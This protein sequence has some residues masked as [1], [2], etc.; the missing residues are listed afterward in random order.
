MTTVLIVDDEPIVRDVVARYLKRDGF[1]TL[2]A[3]DGDAARELIER[4]PPAPRR[5]R[6]DAARHRWP[7]PL[8]VDPVA[9]R[10]ARDHA[11]RP[12][13]GGRPDRRPR[14]RRRRLRHQ[15]LLAARAGDAR[16]HGAAPQQPDGGLERASRR[17]TGSSS[18]RPRARCTLHGQ[19]LRL[20]AKEF[21]L[22]FFLAS[23]PRNVF[24]RDQLMSRVWGYEAALD[25]GTVTVH[26]RRLRAKIELD[27]AQPAPAR[28]D[29]GRRLQVPAVIALALAVAVGTLAVGLAATFAPPPPPQ[30]ATPAGRL[31]AARRRP[32][33]ARR[34]ALR[35][36]DVPHGR[37]RQDPRR[38]GSLCVGGRGGGARA[39]LVDRAPHR[40]PSLRLRRAR[41]GR[42]RRARARGRAARAGRARPV[43]QRDGRQPRRPL[44]R[45]PRARRGGEPRPA[46]AVASI[47]AMLEA[48]EDG[49]ATPDEYLAP[50]QDQAR[51]LTVLVDDLFELA[52]IDAGALVHELA[53]GRARTAR[54]VVR[55]RLRGRGARP[56]RHARENASTSPC[57]GAL[58]ARAGRARPAQPAHERPPPHAIRRHGRGARSPPRRGPRP[59]HGRGHRR[60]PHAGG[61]APDIRPLLARRLRPAGERRRGSRPRD[62][63]RARR[64]PGRQIWAEQR[65]AGGAASPSRCRS[66]AGLM[67]PACRVR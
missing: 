43:V 51:R 18:M 6:R 38:R 45:P 55:P 25:T 52:R 33:A 8:P 27:P 61:R 7:R 20:T 62:R 49:L 40:P 21:D 35:L 44:R 66:P 57:R 13:R 48:I 67:Q 60:R 24:S 14:A 2:E 4:S 50:L 9:R 5:A 63:P 47:A 3:G 1:D 53:G 17:S 41:R 23:N 10:P 58:R 36:G 39:C 54:R 30:R 42:P 31:R 12:R 59:R 32:A 64:S 15:A 28:D 37:R 22:L 11:D 16:A 56:Q 46:G 34:P 19:Q 29:L 26:I 65:A